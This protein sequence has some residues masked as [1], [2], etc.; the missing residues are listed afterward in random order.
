VSVYDTK[1][2]HFISMVAENIDW[3][4]KCRLV[5]DAE[6]AKMMELNYLRLN[7]VDEYN[8]DMGHVDLADQLRGNYQMD[9]WQRQYNG[10]G[11]FG[12]GPLEC[13]VLMLMCFTGRSWKRVAFQ[14]E[15]GS[16]TMSSG[17]K[18]LWLGYLKMNQQ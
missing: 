6:A 11:P 9:R 2:V 8:M 17:N 16:P 15:N 1:P 14:N 12:C 5:F 3:I 4:E 13:F 10:G 7:M 18:L